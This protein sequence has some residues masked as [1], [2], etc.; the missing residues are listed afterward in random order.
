[1]LMAFAS[2]RIG[3][4]FLQV[5][6][7]VLRSWLRIFYSKYIM[8]TSNNVSRLFTFHFNTFQHDNAIFE[9]TSWRNF[10]I[11]CLVHLCLQFS[12]LFHIS[13]RKCFWDR[14]AKMPFDNIE[15]RDVFVAPIR[16]LRHLFGT[17]TMRLKFRRWISLCPTSSRRLV[18]DFHF[19]F[20]SVFCMANVL[21]PTST[22]G[23]LSGKYDFGRLTSLL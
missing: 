12:F 23:Y 7:L 4:M 16:S 15:H 10:H 9:S 18:L 1:M 14:E 6:S 2:A 20:Y 5:M 11:V 21:F 22:C 13:S 19:R 17:T 3:F 8:K